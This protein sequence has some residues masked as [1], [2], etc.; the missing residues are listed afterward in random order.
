MEEGLKLIQVKR[1]IRRG[2]IWVYFIL[3]LVDTAA[4]VVDYFPRLTL[5]ELFNRYLL[6]L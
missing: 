1:G 3:I 4:V 2:V 5:Q 6:P